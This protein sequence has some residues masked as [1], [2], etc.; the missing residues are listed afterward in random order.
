MGT[1]CCHTEPG[2]AAHTCRR[3]RPLATQSINQGKQGRTG[4]TSKAGRLGRGRGHSRATHTHAQ[5]RDHLPAR[6]LSRGHGSK[7][8]PHQTAGDAQNNL[9][10]GFFVICLPA[11]LSKN[12]NQLSLHLV[13]KTLIFCRDPI[14]CLFFNYVPKLHGCDLAPAYYLNGHSSIQE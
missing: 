4:M 9:L 3:T 12:P 11:D 8:T 7:R 2:A 6:G 5:H 1:T 14:D 10:K 13:S